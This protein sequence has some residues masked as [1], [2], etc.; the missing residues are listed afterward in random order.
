[1]RRTTTWLALSAL[2]WCA[3]S[4]VVLAQNEKGKAK[5]RATPPKFGSEVSRIFF[6]DLFSRLQGERPEKPGAVVVTTAPTGGSPG[7]ASE[8]ASYA[9]SKMISAVTIE[10]EIK[11]I[12]LNVDKSV[13]T[14][15]DFA[16]RGHKQV[17]R[18]FSILAAMFAI[19]GEFDDDVRWKKMGPA[20]RDVFARTARNTKAGGNTNTYN[21]A[22]KRK[23]DL[24]DLIGGASLQVEAEQ[25][26]ADWATVCDRGPLMQRLEVGFE[27]KMSAWISS[28]GEFE[29]N[30]E[31]VLHEAEIT[32]VLSEIL[33]KEGMDEWDDEDYVDLA[34]R[35]KEAAIEISS[36][37]KLGNY[38]Q[39]RKASG[40]V[41]K[42]CTDCHEIYR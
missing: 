1:M 22:K 6:D 15:S 23:A 12:K 39:A 37:V 38:D 10:D 3:L 35:M 19:I 33:V 41:K 5:K 21:E 34:K 26:D 18:D 31:N 32:A 4:L 8:G 27:G 25:A 40:E 17:R 20:A 24:Q 30:A 9:W 7:A 29:A 13:T 14:P 2:C 36:A 28:K 11:A 16:G 42:A